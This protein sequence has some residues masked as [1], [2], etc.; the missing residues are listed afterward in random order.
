MFCDARR[1]DDATVAKAT[2]CIIGGGAAGLTMALEFEKRGIDTIVLES[3]GHGPDPHTMDLYR[4]ENVGLPYYFADNYRSRYLGGC[5]NCWGGWCRP[6]EAEDFDK[7]EWVPNSGWPFGLDELR[8]FYERTHSVLRLGPMD[9]DLERWVAAIGRRDVRR[10]PMPEGEL[11]DSL[12]QF[13]LPVRFGKH[14]RRELKAARHARVFLHANVVDVEFDPDGRV[15][16]RVQVRTLTGRSFA[17]EARQFVLACGGLENARIL[18]AC[19][20]QH[21]EGIGNTNGLVGRYFMDHPRLLSGR[22]TLREPWRRNKLYDTMYHY[23]NRAVRAQGTYVAAQMSLPHEV[24][25]R[26][27][28]LNA[29][30]W[31][32]SIFPGEGTPAAEALVRMKMRLHGKADALHSFLGDL[33]TL[34]GQPMNAMH[35]IAARQ[36][37]PLGFLK[38]MHFQMIKDVRLQMI[39]E[40]APNPDSRVTLAGTRDALGMPRARVD[41]RLG[42]QVK[43]TFDRTF[44]LVAK[45]VADAGITE[46]TTLDPP[47]LGRDWPE[48]L[49]GTW[50]HMGTTRMHDSPAQGVVDRNCRIHGLANL[51]V[52]GSSVFPTAGANFPTTTLVALALRLADH[53]RHQL[54]TPDARSRP[55]AASASAPALEAAADARA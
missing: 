35:F 29:R 15:V 26:E 2:V 24:Q 18:L 44:A 22:L 37:R 1:V 6:M 42:D 11:Q 19:N 7:R 14:Y 25:R 9:Y 12:S 55:A 45:V 54:A 46:A 51:Y 33:G 43:H 5:S 4:G 13:S 36:L 39:C 31:F 50:H 10:M 21:A 40:P 17:V 48:S 41:W 52:A 49:E 38:E 34:A 27:R 23:M 16:R 30:V 32:A 53:L 3:G 20:R 47:L 8:P 28:L